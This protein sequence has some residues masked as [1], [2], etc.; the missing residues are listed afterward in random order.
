M[1][2]L[3]SRHTNL[4]FSGCSPIFQAI[5]DDLPDKENSSIYLWGVETQEMKSILQFMY[6]GKSTFY[7]N[8]MSDFLSV[9]RSLKIK[10]NSRDTLRGQD[11]KKN[12]HQNIETGEKDNFS[13][14]Q[15]KV[16]DEIGQTD[17]KV[18]SYKDRAD[19][20]QCN[21]NNHQDIEIGEND[22]SN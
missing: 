19:K 22:S 1:I 18:I 4:F 10:E 14:N 17:T 3:N 13:T 5:I 8:R 11:N 16:I 9:A 21:E 7:Q 20:Y 6:L 2:R 15:S 12:N